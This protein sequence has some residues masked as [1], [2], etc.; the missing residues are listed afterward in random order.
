[1][2][3][4]KCRKCGSEEFY[5]KQRVS[6]FATIHVDNEGKED[7]SSLH[8]SIHYGAIGPIRCIHCD[9]VQRKMTK[10]LKDE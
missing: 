1:M 7:Y 10:E 2:S 4:Y 8:D 9:S 3:K 6:E 5:R